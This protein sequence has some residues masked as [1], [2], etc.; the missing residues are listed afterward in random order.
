[1][2]SAPLACCGWF[3]VDMPACTLLPGRSC[4]HFCAP[5]FARVRL[6]R[7]PWL[8]HGLSRAGQRQLLRSVVLWL[9]LRLSSLPWRSALCCLAVRMC[10][11]LI[12][13]MG[14]CITLCLCRSFARCSRV[15]CQSESQCSPARCSAPLVSLSARS[16][17]VRSRVARQ[18]E[19]QCSPARCSAPRL[20][21]L[22]TRSSLHGRS[23]VASQSESQCS[24]ARCLATLGSCLCAV[25]VRALLCSVC[26]PLVGR[27]AGGGCPRVACQC[28]PQFP[29][30][31]ACLI[32]SACSV[33]VAR[34]PCSPGAVC[35]LALRRHAYGRAVVLQCLCFLCR[36]CAACLGG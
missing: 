26:F 29:S 13:S 9:A 4:L 15:A 27:I 12:L 31:K 14:M 16:L 11:A 35:L 2:C 32:D 18:F 24:P 36:W 3:C 6:T 5:P 25:F 21:C 8:R 7:C 23:R 30:A 19:S 28:G 1:M 22:F 20:S 10:F 17:H 34:L 33:R